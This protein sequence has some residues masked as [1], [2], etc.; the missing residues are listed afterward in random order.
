MANGL[1]VCGSED[2]SKL[3]WVGNVIMLVESSI[4]LVSGFERFGALFPAVAGLEVVPIQA[5]FFKEVE[6]CPILTCNGLE[7]GTAFF[8]IAVHGYSSHFLTN[9]SECV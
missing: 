3:D 4:C 9:Y 8:I 5:S 7:D 1:F 2:T 6:I